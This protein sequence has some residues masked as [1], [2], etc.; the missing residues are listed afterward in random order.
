MQPT[1]GRLLTPREAS[2]LSGLSVKTLA[3]LRCQGGG[4]PY[5][6]IG[7]GKFVRYDQHELASWMRSRRFTSTSQESAAP[8]AAALFPRGKARS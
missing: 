1:A 3:N 6:R 5:Y 7:G 4:A 8:D 2:A